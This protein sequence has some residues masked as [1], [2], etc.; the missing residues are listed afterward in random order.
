MSEQPEQDAP[1]L[2]E[3][4]DAQTVD[5]E[6]EVGTIDPGG[7]DEATIDTPDQLGGTGGDQPGGAG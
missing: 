1:E 4:T 3:P 2:G 5:A 6:A 7:A